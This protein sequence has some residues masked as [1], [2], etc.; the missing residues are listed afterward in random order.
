MRED[1]F[2]IQYI[3][4]PSYQV[5]LELLT[6]EDCDDVIRYIDIVKYPDLYEKYC[7]MKL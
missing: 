6:E 7:F 5:C 3:R 1:R 2:A 4:N